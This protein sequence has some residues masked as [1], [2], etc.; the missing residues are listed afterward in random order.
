MIKEKEKL[1]IYNITKITSR[2][3]ITKNG[4]VAVQN[5]LENSFIILNDFYLKAGCVKRIGGPLGQA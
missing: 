4:S 5:I 3:P 1:N 2:L